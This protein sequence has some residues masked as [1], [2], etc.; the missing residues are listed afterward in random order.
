MPGFNR[1]GPP[2][3]DGNQSGKRMGKC[4]PK[5]RKPKTSDEDWELENEKISKVFGKRNGL[6]RGKGQK[7]HH[8]FRYDDASAED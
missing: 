1:Q 8:R 5:D 3:G 6:G 2:F 4:N 7:K